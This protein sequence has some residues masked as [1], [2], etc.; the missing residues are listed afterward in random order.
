MKHFS[1][2]IRFLKERLEAKKNFCHYLNIMQ[3]LEVSN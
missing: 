1:W 2:E 3:V